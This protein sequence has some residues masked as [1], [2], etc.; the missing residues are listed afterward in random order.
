MSA[1]TDS[2]GILPATY[3][4]QH[5]LDINEPTQLDLFESHDA[6]AAKI[7][8][9]ASA[10]A[11]RAREVILKLM[12]SN[13]EV[14]QVSK[15]VAIASEDSDQFQA[16]S[17]LADSTIKA[18]KELVAI[19]R[20]VHSMIPEPPKE[21][22]NGATGNITQNNIV[23]TGTTADLIENIMKKMKAPAV[24]IENE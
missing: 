12:E 20:D 19:S 24:I 10:D 15:L 1:L 23:F 13:I 14:L 11:E 21:V 4:D 6:E 9:R 7:Y 5:E 18:A 2:L 8:E 17:K 16:Y 3:G 22:V